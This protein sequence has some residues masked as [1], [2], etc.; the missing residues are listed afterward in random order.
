VKD[1]QDYHLRIFNYK[2]NRV[3]KSSQYG[4]AYLFLHTSELIRRGSDS[5]YFPFNSGAEVPPESFMPIFIPRYSIVELTF[6]DA[7]KNNHVRD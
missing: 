4:S 6:R 5:L 1:G 3:R 2:I 7:S